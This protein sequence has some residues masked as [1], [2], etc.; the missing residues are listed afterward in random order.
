MFWNF[1]LMFALIALNGFFV[2]VE[3]AAV[4]ARR[5]RIEVMAKE[6]SRS[7]QIVWRWLESPAARDHLIAATQL[8][9][10][11]VSLALGAVGEKAFAAM[12]EPLFHGRELPAGLEFVERILPSLPLL[13]SLTIV[14]S[15]HVVLGEQ[16]PKVA[17]LRSPEKFA[18]RAA[19]PMM[20]FETT[21]RWFV[22]ALDW[23][24]RFTLRLLGIEET[25]VHGSHLTVEELK[26]IVSES[27][28]SGLL[29]ESGGM[30]TAVLDFGELLVRQ[31]MVPRPEIIAVKADMP[32]SEVIPLFSEHAVTKFPVYEG[33]LDNILGILHIKDVVRFFGTP[34]FEQ[35][36]AREIAREALFVPETLP[37]IEVLRRFRETRR[38]IAIVVDE[39]GGT[40]GL[41]TLED[42]LEEIVG[43]VSDP[44]DEET[45]EIE[46]LA[47]GTAIVDG[48]TLLEDVNETLDVD[49][50]TPYYDTIAGFVLDRLGRIPEVGDV[51]EE[52]G[53]R[54]TVLAM[55]GLRVSR[56][57]IERLEAPS[58]D[59]PLS[60]DA[61]AAE[62]S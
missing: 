47:D 44:F 57:K 11:I 21:F 3:F 39:Y 14:T 34:D 8:G 23:A 9:I 13:L 28:E 12:L 61:P 55:D 58:S 33:D 7:A 54:L 15:F 19:Y 16:V 50:T 59:G 27:E 26:Q 10:T 52:E 38:H 35:K 29:A 2:S 42:L 37:V 25:D 46:I 24:T 56:L 53:V 30:L 5:H 17:T 49:L 40:A 20:L 43:E 60:D 45:P 18:L 41:V 6:G 36:Q 4:A 62:A 31:V 1:V 48:R 22:D 32:L 51:I